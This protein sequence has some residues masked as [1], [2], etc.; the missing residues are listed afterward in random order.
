MTLKLSTETRKNPTHTKSIQNSYVSALTNLFRNYKTK[1][2]EALEQHKGAGRFMQLEPTDIDIIRLSEHLREL[3][4]VFITNP[5]KDITADYVRKSYS[6]GTTYAGMTLKRIGIKAVI[7][8]G[9]ADWRAIDLLKTRNLT[10]LRGITEETNKQIISQLVDG[11]N[12]GEGIP[13]LAKRIVDRV[14][15]IGIVRA[16][17]MARTETLYA[18]NQGALTRYSQHG[19][20][21]VEWLAAI[22]ERTCPTCQAL[23]GKIFNIDENYNL[24]DIPNHVNCR[25]TI[26][27]VIE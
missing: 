6:S 1:A 17:A 2:R 10:A 24:P 27:P 16:K 25:C 3:G 14:D 5:G 7:G 9:P 26:I 20:N 22:G 11:I 13:K 4:Y 15:N 21:K 12:K 8:E 18:V 19:I 23:D